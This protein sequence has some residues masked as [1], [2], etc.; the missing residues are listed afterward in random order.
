M[1]VHHLHDEIVVAGWACRL[2]GANSIGRLWSLLLEGRCAVSEV[3]EDRFPRQRF[4]H[5]RRGE[6]GKSYTFAAGIIDD[7]WGFDPSVF[8]ISPREA[9][10]MDPQQRMLLQLTWEALEDAGIPPSSLAGSDTGVFVGG[11]L[12]EYANSSFADPAV[13]DAHFG[14]GNA[15]SLLSNRI[16]YAFD[17]HGPSMTFDTACS[18]SLVALHQAADA[19]RAGRVSTAIVAGINIIASYTSFISFAQASMLSPTGLCRA[20][21]AKAD[22]FVRAEGGAVL[23]LRKAALAQAE[24]NAIHGVVLASDVNSDGRTNGVALPSAEAQENLLK[25]VYVRAGID[26]ARLA[27]LEAHGTGTPVG[28]PVEATAIGR[29]LGE[30]RDEPL[31][32][33]SIKTNIGHLE[34]ASGLAGVLK[35]LLALN[36]GILPPSLHFSAPNPAIDFAG[37]NLAVCTGSR[38]LTNAE[39]HCAGVNS[40][41]FGGTNAHVVLGPGRKAEA[42][43][44]EKSGRDRYFFISAETKPALGQ[45]AGKYAETI[46]PLSDDGVAQLAGAAAYRRDRLTHRL[47]VTSAKKSTVAHCLDAFE[48]GREHPNL[49][50]GPALGRALASAFV[51]SG[52]GAQWA[53]M[54]IAA[55]RRGGAFRAAF[56]RVDAAFAEVAGWSLAAALFDP[57]LDRRLDATSVSQPLIFAIQCATTAAL[58]AHGFAPAIVLGHSV[59]EVAAAAAAEILDLDSA[60]QLIYHRS[61]LQERVRGAGRMAAI[62][63]SREAA[64]ELAR[65]AGAVEIAA[66]NSPKTTTV[67][68]PAEAIAALKSLAA[69]AGVPFLDLGLDY[70]FHTQAMGPIER[71]LIADL[72]DL[73]PDQ[74]SIPFISTVTGACVPGSLL[75]AGYWWRNVREPVQFMA[76]IRQ[77]R[78]LGVRLFVEIGPRSTLIKH[79]ADCLD[80]DA[81]GCG[82]IGVFERTDRE[83]CDPID[84]AV[85]RALVAGATIDDGA[86]FGAVPHGP[87]RLPTY[88]WQQQPFRYAPTPEAIAVV[89]SER[90][91]LAGARW[92]AEELTWHSHVDTAL[93]PAFADHRVGEQTWLPG[94]AFL[95]IAF[96]L[97]RQWLKSERVAIANFEILRPLDLTNGRS[98]ELMSRVAPGSNVVEISSRPRL[99]QAAW[100]LNA[101]GKMMRAAGDA[102]AVAAAP[103]PDANLLAG[104]TIYEIADAAGLHYGPA[105]RLARRVAC[106]GARTSVELAAST[107]A[108]PYIADPIRIDAGMHGMIRVFPELRA[109]ERGVAYVPTQLETA[110]LHAA[111]GV[112][113]ASHMILRRK[114]ERSILADCRIFDAE[115]RLLAD[116]VGV[117]CQ[118]VPVRRTHTLPATGLVERFV[119]AAGALAGATGVTS[120]PRDV[121][122]AAAALEAGAGAGERADSAKAL[123]LLDAWATAAAYQLALALGARGRVD[124]DRLLVSGALAHAQRPWLL[125]WLRN[126]EAAGLARK[127]GAGWKIIR[128]PSLP[129]AADVLRALAQEHPERAADLLLAGEVSTLA[130]D[131]GALAAFARP[132][133]ASSF[134]ALAAAL[135]AN[136]GDFFERLLRTVPTIF[137]EHRSLRILQAGAGAMLDLGRANVTRLDRLDD[138]AQ[139]APASYDL[140]VAANG[141]HDLPHADLA[142]LAQALAPGGML[143]ALEAQPSLFKDMV[144]GLEPGWFEDRDPVSAPGK[145]RARAQWQLDL[146][147]AG[148]A[149]IEACDVSGGGEIATLLAATPPAHAQEA[150][151]ATVPS[152]RAMF[153]PD[154][155]RGRELAEAID[156]SLGAGAVEDAADIVYFVPP[157]DHGAPAEQVAARCLALKAMTERLSGERRKIWLVFA[158][159]RP[160]DAGDASPVASGVWAFSRTLANEAPQLDMRRVDL[161]L[162]LPAQEAAERLSRLVL[163]GTDETELQIGAASTRV[164]RIERR[165]NVEGAEEGGALRLQAHAVG[166]DHLRWERVGRRAPAADEIEIEVRATGLNFRDVMW[167]LS[168]LPETML[169][170]GFGG[171]TLGLECAGTVVRAGDQVRDLREGDRVMAFAGNAFAT[172]ATIPASQ[173]AKIPDR[174]GF[175]A[176]ATIPVAFL[177][178]FYALVTLARLKRGEWVLIHGGAGGVGMAAIQIA[179]AR[180]AKVIATAGSTAKRSLLR[181]LGVRH[182]FDSR[183]LEFA[184]KV[185]QLTGEGVDVVLN[186]LAGEAME[187]S[188]ACL[189]PFGRF[190]E[191]GKR[192]YVGN[193]HVGLRPFRKNL[194][195][196]GID[197]DQLLRGK[198]SEARRVLRDVMRRIDSGS[199]SPLPY[200]MFGAAE[201][202]DAFHLMQQSGH[203]GKIVVAP[204][205]VPTPAVS[206]RAAAFAIDPA[207]THLVTG[208][209]GGFGLEVTK[210]LVKEGAR[211][212]VLLG[213]RGPADDAAKALVVSLRA[214]GA[215]ILAD[216]CDVGNLA[217]LTRVFEKF[218]GELP[219]LGG[220]IHAAMVLD[221][222]IVANLDAERFAR[223]LAPKVRGAENLD[224]LTERMT[225]DYFVLFS[226]VTTLIGNP[227]Q[228]NYVAANAY[229]EGL[230]RRRRQKRLPALAIGWG[231]ITDV[232]VVARNERLRAGLE[233]VTGGGGMRSL[234]ALKLM[235]EALGQAQLDEDLAVLTIAPLDDV[236]G[237][238]RLAVLRSPSFAALASAAGAKSDEPAARID[239][240]EMMRTENA[241]AVR[242]RVGGAIIAQLADVLHAR[243]ED[244]DRLRPLGELGLDSLMALE[245]AMNLERV[246]AVRLSLAGAS[247]E[248]TVARLAEEIMLQAA[249]GGEPSAAADVVPIALHHAASVAPGEVEKLGEILHTAGRGV[250]AQ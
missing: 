135:A 82:T 40:F 12:T 38:L 164:L 214:R 59:G 23:V 17:L 50:A 51:Y 168:L 37:L 128:E 218:G 154:D 141:L 31:P 43:A 27:F 236:A 197:V 74:G 53:G 18:S 70:P 174:L 113:A 241:E 10:Q 198:G 134:H 126:L 246:F 116:F 138:A 212:L 77:A 99:T 136:A 170:D 30:T 105:F 213:R 11:S 133:L 233:R 7:P 101:R 6:R 55:H 244:I 84:K 248:M 110:T 202:A 62:S 21:D 68:G 112:P 229:M 48:S 249:G 183:T 203:I 243:A 209:F 155:E 180:G 147:A 225:L 9:E 190:C 227:G 26:P 4:L 89:E 69:D 36:H 211:N 88:P 151:P 171:P 2:P 219:P 145:L 60:V 121:M 32:I 109:A 240:R 223:V 63:A 52:N 13:V 143:I 208:A 156:R 92:A 15:L 14:T 28:D 125:A 46:A 182:V 75:D 247:G 5:P 232:G 72:R 20:F 122:R 107:A 187:H 108:T 102:V 137:P 79:I 146:R 131:P 152:V 176:A 186:S 215:S 175:A 163:T 100:A 66:V 111:F 165:G 115:G 159:A 56:D 194:T 42:G 127:A 87:I 235:A 95:E 130:G 172:H 22:G 188:I 83:D 206:G 93:F 177:T 153:E 148:F 104:E 86:A 54:G 200:T 117:H 205:P 44:P 139:L 8:A 166:R 24:G 78:A 132:A 150:G 73:A 162:S 61:R 124:P 238:D 39:K 90:H 25:R 207:K 195:Y 106:D 91:P 234:D 80:G 34:P 58:A 157:E 161:S 226:S 144:L 216:P 47:V 220:V 189:K 140:V 204:P 158:G 16:S 45:L 19:L 245:L 228:G 67:A 230:A 119:P 237:A 169:E 76:A 191:L 184:E 129:R 1:S 65:G 185:R 167:Q 35:A 181:A 149:A 231:P 57:A 98:Y 81:G 71:P 120:E 201:I 85:A 114:S 222:A 29:A 97:A 239:L 41:G 64:A 178:A 173:A 49:V 96:A 179:R 199:F 118:A 33:G 217:Q 242:A 123:R 221:D 196:F 103:A 3:P 250:A 210:W 142:R 193:T 160:D 224:R 94:T 192:D